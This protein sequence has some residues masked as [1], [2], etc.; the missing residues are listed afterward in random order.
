M[1]SYFYVGRDR[2]FSEILNDVHHYM[3]EKMQNEIVSKNLDN[4]AK[5]IENFLKTIKEEVLNLREQNKTPYYILNDA[6]ENVY[7]IVADATHKIMQSHSLIK[8]GSSLFLRSHKVKHIQQ[9]G[10]IFE[11]QFAGLVASLLQKNNKQ[12]NVN[13]TMFLTGNQLVS[14]TA[15]DE[16][17]KEQKKEII[18]M[19]NQAVKIQAERMQKKTPQSLKNIEKIQANIGKA[20]VSVPYIHIEEDGD[21]FIK[22]FLQAISGANFSLKNY[23][24]F[25]KDVEERIVEKEATNIKL[26]LGDTVLPKSVMGALSEILQ[27]EEQQGVFYRGMEILSG[28][29]EDPDTATY[30]EVSKHFSHLRFIY[31]LRGSGLTQ[32]GSLQTVDFIIWNDPDSEKIAV[33]STASLILSRWQSYSSLFSSVSMA[34]SA[35]LKS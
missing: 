7:Q 16:L 14:L 21:P 3:N 25:K 35:L 28:R 4:R 11:E 8:S 33:R 34:A 10:D 9:A 22:K 12:S 17:T 2:Q 31:E 27:V 18:E 32:N 30:E 26:H 23:S 20:D 6:R 19:T 29:S 15:I 24:S 1:A 5:E 13:I